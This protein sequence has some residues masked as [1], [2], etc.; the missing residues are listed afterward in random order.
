MWF[1]GRRTLAVIQRNQD[2]RQDAK[3]RGGSRRLRLDLVNDGRQELLA[4]LDQ[5]AVTLEANVLPEK[6][7]STSK[8]QLFPVNTDRK[9]QTPLIEQL[10]DLNDVFARVGHSEH[11][12]RAGVLLAEADGGTVN[13][14]T[15]IVVHKRLGR[16]AA[17]Y[18]EMKRK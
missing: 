7:Q 11:G 10:K 12:W 1:I 9:T 2:V 8:H 15:N 3:F 5:F 16:L 14:G 18:F 17:T 13:Q 6:P 4:F